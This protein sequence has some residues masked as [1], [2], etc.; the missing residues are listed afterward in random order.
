[1]AS[2]LK[3]LPSGFVFQPSELRLVGQ[4]F[5]LALAK[6]PESD[7]DAVAAA[8]FHAARRGERDPQRLLQ[9]ALTGVGDKT[10]TL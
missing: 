4:A 6:H 9:A 8:I 3:F 1:M 5:D 2:I 10:P 7:R